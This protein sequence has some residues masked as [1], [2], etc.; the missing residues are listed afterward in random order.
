ML[1]QDLQVY[2]HY[3]DLSSIIISIII[4]AGSPGGVETQP[5][6]HGGQGADRDAD[7]GG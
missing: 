7:Q 4:V 2:F 6:Q 1:L 5:V 3:F